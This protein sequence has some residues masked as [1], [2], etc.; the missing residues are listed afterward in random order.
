MGTKDKQDFRKMT[1]GEALYS[2]GARPAEKD[3]KK[4]LTLGGRFIEASDA[5]PDVIIAGSNKKFTVKGSRKFRC[6]DCGCKVWLA[7]GG[8]ETHRHYPDAPVLCLTCAM[9]KRDT[10]NLQ[11]G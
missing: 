4:G 7:P 5:R 6:H 8:Q 11:A 10:E 9:M 2:I 3:G 1:E